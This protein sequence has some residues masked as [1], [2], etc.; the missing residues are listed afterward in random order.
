LPQAYIHI[1][2]GGLDFTTPPFPIPTPER[3]SNSNT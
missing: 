2:A 1:L 3:R